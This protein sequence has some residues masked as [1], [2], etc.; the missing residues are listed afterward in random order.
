MIFKSNPKLAIVVP[1]YNEQ[2][3]IETTILRLLEVLKELEE[4]DLISRESFLYL[5]DDGSCDGTFDIIKS[6]YEKNKKVKVLNL[7]VISAI[8]MRFWQACLG[9]G[10]L[11]PIAQLQLCG[12]AAD[13]N[14]IKDFVQN[15]KRG[16]NLFW[17]LEE[18]PKIIF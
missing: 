4:A 14:I 10:K 6:F 12:F 11:V 18:I 8:K 17:G 5:V 15:I 2:E 16:L 1:C 13:E 7:R 3:A 9:Q